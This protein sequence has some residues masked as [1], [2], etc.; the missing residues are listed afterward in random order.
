LNANTVYNN[1]EEHSLLE[2]IAHGDQAAFAQIV[3]KYTNIIYPYLLY[4]LKRTHEA[5]ELTQDIFLRLWRN[6]AKLPHLENFPGY[7]FVV[8][9]NRANS[10]L[11]AQLLGSEEINDDRLSSLLTD[12]SR[13]LENKE[14]AA[15]LDEGIDALPPRRREVFLLSRLE[16]QTYEAIAERL[17]ISRSAVRQHIVEALVFLRHYLKEHAGIIVSLAGWLFWLTV[18][19][20]K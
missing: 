3:D 7:V 11:K 19:L 16:E 20:K 14:L 1:P 10:A 9:R 13:S 2:R 4:W 12:P 18:V 17:G 6:R 5:E 15:I 8:T